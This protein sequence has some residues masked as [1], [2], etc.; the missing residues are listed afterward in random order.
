MIHYKVHV[1][2]AADTSHS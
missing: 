2:T 1:T